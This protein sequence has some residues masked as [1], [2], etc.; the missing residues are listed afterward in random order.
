[1]LAKAACSSPSS[2]G[3]APPR[4]GCQSPPPS[5]PADSPKSNGG[6]CSVGREAHYVLKTRTGLPDCHCSLSLSLSLSL[7]HSA[8]IEHIIPSHIPPPPTHPS[9]GTPRG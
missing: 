7:S 6:R 3:Q 2:L 9:I 1:P 8:P 4:T 5:T